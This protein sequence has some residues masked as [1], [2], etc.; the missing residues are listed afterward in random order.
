VLHG[1]C[2]AG[3]REGHEPYRFLAT[4]AALELL[5]VAAHTA[6]STRNDGTAGWCFGEAA[7]DTQAG[8]SHPR[9]PGCCRFC[10]KL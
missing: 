6:S 7:Q 5:A 1:L 9:Q 2:A 8:S 4:C 3:T 10:L